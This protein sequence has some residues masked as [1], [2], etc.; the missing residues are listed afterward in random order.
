MTQAAQAPAVSGSFFE[1]RVKAKLRE[2]VWEYL[3][4]LLG[5]KKNKSN[6]Q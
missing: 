1:I 6:S 5:M 3:R 2:F 4:P